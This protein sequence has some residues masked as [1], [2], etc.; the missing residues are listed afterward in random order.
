MMCDE[1]EDARRVKDHSASVKR[2][3]RRRKAGGARGGAGSL[4]TS[5]GAGVKF[6]CIPFAKTS[7]QTS[8]T[9]SAMDARLA[10]RFIAR[11]INTQPISDRMPLMIRIRI[12]AVTT[13]IPFIPSNLR[14]ALT[15]VKV[16][17]EAESNAS[18]H[19]DVAIRSH[20]IA[21]L[22]APSVICRAR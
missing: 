1:N 16:C 18:K 6:V 13:P 19:S 17:Q 4:A 14:L 20:H 3:R 9:L 15:D 5:V 22:A 12:C 2:F 8:S 11:R 21:Y 7:W 10:R